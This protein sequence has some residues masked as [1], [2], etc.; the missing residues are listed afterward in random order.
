MVIILNTIQLPPELSREEIE[1]IPD[2]QNGCSPNVRV[3]EQPKRELEEEEQQQQVIKLSVETGI[4][5]TILCFLSLSL[6]KVKLLKL[7]LRQRKGS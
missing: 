5:M 3:I 1:K 4:I 2:P 6:F 7:M